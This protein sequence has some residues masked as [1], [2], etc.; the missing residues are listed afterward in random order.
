MQRLV[1]HSPRQ[2]H[3]FTPCPPTTEV[4]AAAAHSVI[5]ATPRQEIKM[6]SKPKVPLVAIG[7]TVR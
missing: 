1:L 4:D 2:L 6:S 7:T 3:L 5:A